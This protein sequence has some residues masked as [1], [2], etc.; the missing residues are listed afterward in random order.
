VSLS[1]GRQVCGNFFC[2]V[3][4]VYFS[5]GYKNE[6]MN[7]YKAFLFD[8]NGTMVDDMSYHINA[9]HKIFNDLGVPLSLEETK[10]QCYGKNSEV[11]ER[12]LPGRFSEEDKN[13]MSIEKETKYQQLFRPHLKLIEGLDEFLK[14]AHKAGIKM[15]IGS[16][17][18]MYNVNFVLDGLHLHHYFQAIV[19]ADDVKISK[20]D[21]ETFTKCAENLH[22]SP[23]D[24]LVFE[25]STMGAESALHAGMKC[26]AITTMHSK[27]EFTHAN[28]IQFTDSY[29]PELFRLL[30]AAN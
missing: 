27:E 4:V 10:K 9:W 13:R 12:V 18:I 26:V 11:I 2:R 8:L 30:A 3:I 22:I 24:C 17:A 5:N 16:A 28:I 21:P 23:E 1:G 20:P 6:I 25:D 29:S 15:A 7:R 19:S 14:E